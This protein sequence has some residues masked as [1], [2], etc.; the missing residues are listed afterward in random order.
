MIYYIASR[1]NS[2]LGT[3]I[4]RAPAPITQGDTVIFDNITP[5]NV[6]T[7]SYQDLVDA[8]IVEPDDVD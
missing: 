4:C 6:V 2:D 7:S 5:S 8:G 3:D 1:Y